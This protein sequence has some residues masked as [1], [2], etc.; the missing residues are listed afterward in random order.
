[1]RIRFS[2]IIA[3]APVLFVAFSLAT[4]EKAAGYRA[5]PGYPANLIARWSEHCRSMIAT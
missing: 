4:A 5:H 3:N 2:V 1:M